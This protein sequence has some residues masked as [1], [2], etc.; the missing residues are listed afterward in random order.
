MK[1]TIS[2]TVV[3]TLT[4]LAI[5]IWVT[6]RETVPQ[7]TENTETE[8]AQTTAFTIIAFGDSLTAGYGLPLSESYPAQLEVALRKSDYSVSVI[9]A[10]VS[11][12]TSRGN[13]ERAPFIR[14]QNPDIVLIGIGG[15]DALRFLPI[16][17]TR[18]NMKKTIEIL[19]AG[20]N[21]PRI[22]LLSMQA[23]LNAGSEYKKEFDTLYPELAR[24]YTLPLMPFIT[25]AVF[26]NEEYKLQD[27]IH[28]NREGYAKVI[29]DYI[30]NVVENI[31]TQL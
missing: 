6:G 10:G 1:K 17:E 11:G 31:L 3:L 5:W 24:I 19:S 27:G 13:L 30:L 21:P 18:A 2:I 15:N 22:I 9:N 12:E 25:E 7:D 26:L 16:D 20:E 4:L 28:L 8:Q 14:A 23:P 29:D